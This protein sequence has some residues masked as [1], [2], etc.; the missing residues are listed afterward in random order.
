MSIEPITIPMSIESNEVTIE[1]TFDTKIEV[2]EGGSI[3]VES[4]SVNT[5]GTTTAPTGKAYSP[6]VVNVPNSYTNSDEGKVV[7]NGALTAQTSTTKNA[8]G[9]Y[10]TTTIKQVTVSVPASAVDSGTKSITS[11]GNNQDVVGYAAVNVAVPNSYSAADEG[12]VVSSG[13]LVSQ[14]AHADATPTTSDQTI[15]TTTNNSI[16]VKGDADLVATNI[17]KDVEIF[18]VT[19][20]YEGGGG[21][22]DYPYM[23]GTYG[24]VSGVTTEVYK[25]HVKLTSTS[26]NTSGVTAGL[27]KLDGTLNIGTEWFAV[28]SGSTIKVEY[29]NVVNSSNLTWNANGKNTGSTT[30]LSFGIGN[31]THTS[32]ATYTGTVTSNTSVGQWF[33]YISSMPTGK[34]LEFDMEISIDGTRIL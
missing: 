29:K 11:N 25:N 30:S 5:N 3:T 26:N 17:K 1:S 32:G 10:D 23:L 28:N 31:G 6:V 21:S 33:V 12:K 7:K 22:T 24:G 4:L 8:N 14:T 34:V 19:G 20:S 2:V 9:T 13:A 18:G 27:R 15:D 16:K